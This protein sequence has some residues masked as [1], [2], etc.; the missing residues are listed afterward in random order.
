M[1][2]TPKR[3][4]KAV[5]PYG[6][7]VAYRR[8]RPRLDKNK[9][10]R[11]R[12]REFNQKLSSGLAT[13]KKL[14]GSGEPKFVVSLTSYNKRL[15]TAAPLALASL[16]NQSRMP[17]KIVLWVA[18]GEKPP[19]SVRQFEKL[20]LEIKFCK[21]IKS[22]KKLVPALKAYPE[23]V[24]IT[25]DDDIAYP[26]DWLAK[27]IKTHKAHPKLIL[28]HRGR[29]ITVADGQPSSY[30]N[31]P[32]LDK[33][34]K[35]SHHMLP[36]G[37]GG[38]LYPPRSLSDKVFDEDVFM[39]IAP[40][41][42]DLWFWA[43]AELKGTKRALVEKSHRNFK[44][45]MLDE[46]GL[47]NTVNVDG[48]DTQFAKILKKFPEIANN[49]GSK[50]T[51][52]TFPGS[53][54]Y[55][56]N[57]Y[58][59]GGDSG[60]GSYDNLAIFKA[61][62]LNEFVKE[63]KIQK[64]MEFGTGDGNQLLIAKYPH[65]IGY[66]VSETSTEM[67]RKLF[68]GDKTKEFYTLDKYKNQKADLTMSLDV[69]YHLVEQKVFEDHINTLFEAS[70]KFVIIY[71]FD[72]DN[73]RTADHVKSRKF[74]DYIDANIKGWKLY[75]HI[76]NKYPYDESNPDHTTWADFYVYEQRKNH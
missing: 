46:V 56:E 44:D 30:N 9:T 7:V 68:K 67:C 15:K 11:I 8:A 14:K 4:V 3:A 23:S 76:P 2:I 35:N 33:T 75:Q 18:N 43:M 58:K 73:I 38:I 25:A 34:I 72:G 12:R 65:Y 71:A 52:T 16:F 49:I 61:E 1:K 69:L 45:L 40:H 63:N 20:G 60:T 37:I 74:T 28:A 41:G 48:N 47:Y 55:W 51:K 50:T 29:Q 66:D 42:D 31:W 19:R 59:A 5:T 27:M 57:R 17:D 39:S 64:V 24:I 53:K 54:A 26:K 62:V 36:N 21:D 22:Y 32:L 70:T 13:A 10:E 6:M